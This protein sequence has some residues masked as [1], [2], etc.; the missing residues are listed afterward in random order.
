M[1]V[2]E[3]PSFKPEFPEVFPWGWVDS[4]HLT[5]VASTIVNH[6]RHDMSKGR[7]NVPGLRLAL[8]IIAE[9]AEV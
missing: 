2:S 3:H 9:R 4:I 6:I 5:N 1:K 7:N 8:N